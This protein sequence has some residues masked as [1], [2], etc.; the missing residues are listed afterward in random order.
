MEIW[1]ESG[2][3]LSRY[4]SAVLRL[5]LETPVQNAATD[6]TEDKLL[7]LGESLRYRL[8]AAAWL[9]IKNPEVEISFGIVWSP[10]KKV[11]V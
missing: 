5:H 7:M 8:D 10:L 11:A 6:L 2:E 9:A 4:N 1:E 3:Y